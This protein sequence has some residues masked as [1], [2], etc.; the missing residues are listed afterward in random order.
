MPEKKSGSVIGF[1]LGEAEWVLE[2]GRQ[3]KAGNLEATG[4]TTASCK[5]K[6]R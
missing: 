6:G 4:W 2:L 1:E 3:T 5:E